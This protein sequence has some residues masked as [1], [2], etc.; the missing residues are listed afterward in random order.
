MFLIWAL[1]RW[2]YCFEG[3]K[4]SFEYLIYYN[5]S[6]TGYI[7]GVLTSILFR[8]YMNIQRQH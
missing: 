2:S 7:N 3:K 8:L 5:H 4:I 6:G 1:H